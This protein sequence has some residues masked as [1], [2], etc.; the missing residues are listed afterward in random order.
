[1]PASAFAR[2][3]RDQHQR[4]PRDGRVDRLRLHI[5]AAGIQ[6]ASLYVVESC[7]LGRIRRQRQH[8]RREVH[9][10]HRTVRPD[11]PSRQHC[12]LSGAGRHIEHSMSV[13]DARQV[14]HPFCE[15]REE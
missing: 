11:A 5:E 14:E 1:M 3:L 4:Q 2:A 8:L 9:G 6:H 13:H 12:L 7:L 10:Q 15:R